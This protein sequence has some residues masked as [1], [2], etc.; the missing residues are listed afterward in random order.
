MLRPGSRNQL[1]GFY[2]FS[3]AYI[4]SEESEMYEEFRTFKLNLI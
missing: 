3:V 1:K 2:E 4:D